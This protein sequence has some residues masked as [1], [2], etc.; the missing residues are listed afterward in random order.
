M[1]LQFVIF[2]N[3]AGAYV[4]QIAGDFKLLL[5]LLIIYMKKS[6]DRQNVDSGHYL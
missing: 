5:K 1:Q 2:E 3:F 4:R 6:Q